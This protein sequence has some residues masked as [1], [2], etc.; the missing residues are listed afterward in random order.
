M[1]SPPPKLHLTINEDNAVVRRGTS[2]HVVIAKVL[3]RERVEGDEIIYLDRMVHGPHE[4]PEG[5]GTLSGAISTIYTRP[6]AAGGPS[7][8]P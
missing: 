1:H 7:S 6:V 8:S 5:G 3:G 4:Q 2:T